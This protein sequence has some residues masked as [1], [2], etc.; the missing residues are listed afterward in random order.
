MINYHKQCAIC[1][2]NLVTRMHY[3]DLTCENISCAKYQYSVVD[4][5]IDFYYD[6]YIIE[7]HLKSD[8]S[9][10]RCTVVKRGELIETSATGRNIYTVPKLIVNLEHPIDFNNQ[11]LHFL[12]RLE[13]LQLFK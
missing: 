6:G 8:G 1:G 7:Y 4:N 11:P 12:Q 3:S 10:L 5:F 9:F 13:K 2:S